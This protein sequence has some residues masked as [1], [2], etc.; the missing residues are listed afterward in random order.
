M[1]RAPL[2]SSDYWSKVIHNNDGYI[3]KSQKALR[4][5][6]GRLTTPPSTLSRL[7]KSIGIKSC[8]GILLEIR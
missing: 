3:E 6:V 7:P 2:G 4:E 8:A 5:P 1:I